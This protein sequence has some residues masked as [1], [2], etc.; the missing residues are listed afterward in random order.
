MSHPRTKIRNR[1][2][3]LIVDATQNVPVELN[4]A[5]RTS[6]YPYINISSSEDLS[7][8][9]DYTPTTTAR[10]YRLDVDLYVSS[11]N[12]DEETD[13]L[14]KII[15]Q[16]IRD[17]RKSTDWSFIFLSNITSPELEAGDVDYATTNLDIQINY[18]VQS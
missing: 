4:R 17:N 7:E 3:G 16:V 15:E 10:R 6:E 1:L 13:D 5:H 14:I 12:Q 2:K 18:E 8:F 11:L 9:D